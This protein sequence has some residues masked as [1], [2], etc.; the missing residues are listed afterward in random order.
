MYIHRPSLIYFG[1]SR[2]NEVAATEI[3]RFTSLDRSSGFDF[4]PD[5]VH[6]SHNVHGPGGAIGMRELR[7]ARRNAKCSSYIT[8]RLLIQPMVLGD[9]DLFVSLRNKSRARARKHIEKFKRCLCAR[10]CLTE[11][12]AHRDA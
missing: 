8:H 7:S 3:F 10:L 6:R 9:T 1:T 5:E 12:R 4:V 2:K 11:G